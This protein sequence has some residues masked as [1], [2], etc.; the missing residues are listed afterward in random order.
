[1]IVPTPRKFRLPMLLKDEQSIVNIGRRFYNTIRFD[2]PM[3][4]AC[5]MHVQC[6]PCCRS[7]H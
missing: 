4:P 2:D 5:R 1:M 6:P 7:N 3:L